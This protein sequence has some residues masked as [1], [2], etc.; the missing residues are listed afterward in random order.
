MSAAE[1]GRIRYLSAPTAVS[2]GDDWY[3]V[4]GLEHFW[5]RRR[6]EVLCRIA[7]ELIRQAP[8]MAEVGCGH[9]LLQRQVEDFYNRDVTGFDLNEVALMQTVSRTS[10][11]C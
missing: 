11:V 9:G 4:A 7:G 3:G 6:F 8:A 10:P 5:V 2:M 1:S